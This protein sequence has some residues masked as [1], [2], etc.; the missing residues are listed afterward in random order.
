MRIVLGAQI[1]HRAGGNQLPVELREL[2]AK[3]IVHVV[4]GGMDESGS[5]ADGE[6]FEK[7]WGMK[8][9]FVDP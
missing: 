7:K 9:R 8:S 3:G 6:S 2:H 4:P 5:A 1:Q